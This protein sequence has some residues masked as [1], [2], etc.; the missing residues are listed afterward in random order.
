MRKLILIRHSLPRIDSDAA[1]SGWTL[2][3]EGRRRCLPVADAISVHAPAAVVTSLE[4]K[5]VETGRI[6]AERLGL[7][8]ET[9]EGLHEHER[10]WAPWRGSD[11]FEASVS[12]F[13]E[14]PDTLVL[15]DETATQARV[16]F[17]AALDAVL[18]RFQAGNLAVVSHGTVISALVAYHNALDPFRFWK[19]LGLPAVLLLEVPGFRLIHGSV[20]LPE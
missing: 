13:F 19:G 8:C 12:E 4:P 18:R 16:R 14:R 3:P 5:A 9:A 17:Q 10:P 11:A 15:G 7:P 2:S 6:V 1:A 20:H